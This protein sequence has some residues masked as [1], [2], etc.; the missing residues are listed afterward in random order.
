[1]AGILAGEEQPTIL[2]GDMNATAS[3]PTLGPLLAQLVDAW[4]VA[5]SGPEGSG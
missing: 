1:M 4:P 2:G 3:T 5:G